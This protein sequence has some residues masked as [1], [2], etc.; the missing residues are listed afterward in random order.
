MLVL[1]IRV[2]LLVLGEIMQEGRNAAWF[3]KK[4]ILAEAQ[5]SNQI[6]D[7]EKLAFLT[8]LGIPNGQAAQTTIQ[9]TSAFKTEDLDAYDSDCYDVSNAKAFLMAN[10]SN[11]G[12]DIISEVPHFEQNH[13]DLDN[14]SVHAM[15]SFEQTPVVNFW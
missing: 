6:L 7:E 2:M 12:S 9:N 15:Q 14:Q 13:T 4:A 8:N 3:K 10:L 5:E 11:Y 1:D